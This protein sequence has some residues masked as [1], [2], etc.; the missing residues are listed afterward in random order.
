[1]VGVSG[2]LKCFFGPFIVLII[3]GSLYS[4]INRSAELELL[5]QEM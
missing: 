1:M 5:L 2:H 3:R 4:P